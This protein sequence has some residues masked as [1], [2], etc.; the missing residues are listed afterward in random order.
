MKIPIPNEN[1]SAYGDIWGTFIGVILINK[2]D[3]LW[4]IM[5]STFE[6]K[7]LATLEAPKINKY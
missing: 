6:L 5:V 2:S 3:M 1:Q 4:L 7:A